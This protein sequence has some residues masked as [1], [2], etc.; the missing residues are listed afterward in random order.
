MRYVAVI[1]SAL[2]A[3]LSIERSALAQTTFG[4]G[5]S[6]P[7]ARVAD[8]RRVVGAL[9]SNPAAQETLAY[10]LGACAATYSNQ[11]ASHM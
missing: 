4:A 1:L 5:R 11:N 7:C 8:D 2:F 6:D 10:D 3:C 9:P